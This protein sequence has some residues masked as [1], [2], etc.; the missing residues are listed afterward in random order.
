[1]ITQDLPPAPG[2][3]VRPTP[4]STPTPPPANTNS[5]LRPFADSRRGTGII[6]PDGPDSFYLVGT[7]LA[8]TFSSREPGRIA[9]IGIAEE[10]SFLNGRWMPGRRLN[11]DETF[12]AYRVLLPPDAVQAIH[13]TLYSI[14]Q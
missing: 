14:P 12:G 9:R 8:L 6:L 13:V 2:E 3:T 4:A 10:G 7:G 5:Y 1:V 11:G